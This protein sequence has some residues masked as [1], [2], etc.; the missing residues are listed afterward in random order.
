MH[1]AKLLHEHP[2]RVQHEQ[3]DGMLG[4]AGLQ[5]GHHAWEYALLPAKLTLLQP[6]QRLLVR[7]NPGLRRHRVP[8]V[9]LLSRNQFKQW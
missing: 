8:V 4:D 9:Q 2:R 3:H 7:S 1:L 6:S 5:L